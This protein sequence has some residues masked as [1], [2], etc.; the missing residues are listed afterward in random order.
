MIDASLPAGST[1][2]ARFPLFGAER[3]SAEGRVYAQIVDRLLDL[4]GSSQRVLVTS[5]GVGEGKSV[6]AVNLAYAFHARG[7]SV[8][9]AEFAFQRPIFADIFG[10]SPLPFGVE[11][12]VALGTSLDAVVCERADGLSIAL[13]SGTRLE[14]GDLRP[15]PELDQTLL[16]A[17]S[18][19]AWTILDGPS[20]A[21]MEE[22]GSIAAAVGITLIVARAA[23][24][25][26]KA[27]LKAIERIHHPRT[28]V[29]L[30]D[31]PARD[32]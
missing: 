3:D 29:V 28:F 21:E 1:L 9:L 22:A 20:V 12:A 32:M 6:T 8:L 13:A 17:S 27:L 30:N 4:E 5:P 24:T 15:G 10:P 16:E 26:S 23:E 14:G 19:F 18:S 11:D 7:I 31:V 2:A 25:E